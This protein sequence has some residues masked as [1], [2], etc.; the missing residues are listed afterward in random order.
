MSWLTVVGIGED[1]V[2]GLSPAARAAVER[3]EILVG[4]DRHLGMIA[5]TSAECLRW[6]SPLEA[7]LPEIERHRGRRVVALASGDP[8]WFGIGA[9]LVRH[10]A[11]SD[12]TILPHTG[13]FSLAAARLG[14]PLAEVATISLHGR[15]LDTL[16][17]HLAPGARVLA[18][19]ENGRTGEAVARTLTHAGWGPSG[20]T[21]LEHLG[22]A[23]ERRLDGTAADWPHPP[24]ADLNLLAIV[25]RPGPKAVAFPRTPGLP[26]DAFV[27]DGQLTKREV[28]AATLAAL[29]PLPGQTLWDVGAGCGSIGIEWMRAA[30]RTTAIAI[31]RDEA[32]RD[33][34]A[35]NAAALGVPG[36]RIVAGEA[37]AALTGLPAPDAVFIGGGL[38]A[39]QLV[40]T[41]LSALKPGGRLVANAVTLEAEAALVALRGRHG[42]ELVRLA[43][44]RAAP[45]GPFQGWRS[46]MPVTQWAL[47][48]AHG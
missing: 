7:S 33:Y 42:G 43:I 27:H 34:I 39:P 5:P 11:P 32:R 30:E 29:A 48:K 3:A 1:G 20:L 4:G 40:E 41:C 19:S 2:P 25:C 21:V 10:F 31:E 23:A 26:D 6:E 38:S 35:R 36:L 12:M 46:L 8:M 45:V 37:P 17:L 13:A 15:P 18:L 47:R 44:S 22:G 9:T 14:W 16:A 24:G 28:R